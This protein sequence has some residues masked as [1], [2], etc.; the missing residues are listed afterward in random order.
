MNKEQLI[1]KLVAKYG[2]ENDLTKALIT[3]LVNTTFAEIQATVLD[4]KRVVIREFGAF[5]PREAKAKG[6]RPDGSKWTRP[7]KTS[8]RFAPYKASGGASHGEGVV[9]TIPA[10]EQTTS[11]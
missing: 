1:K 4:G 9:T 2:E 3:K 10:P 7:V 8:V 5:F 6:Q 11:A